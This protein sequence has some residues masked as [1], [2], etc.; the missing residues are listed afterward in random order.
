[1]NDWPVKILDKVGRFL[2]RTLF[3]LDVTGLENLPSTGPV[4][5][6][7]NHVNFTDVGMLMILMPRRPVGLA[8][9]ELVRNP[10]LGPIVRTLGVIPVRRGEV[11][12]DALRQSSELL[13]AGRRVLMI[14]P[15]GHRSGHGRL[16]E[17]HDG[18]TFVAIRSGAMLVPIATHGNERFWR[19]VFTLRKTRAHIVIGR[20]FRFRVSGGRPDR[21][22]LHAMTIEA[23]YRLA[24]LLPAEYRGVYSDLS[25]ATTKHLDFDPEK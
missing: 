22:A 7:T 2:I 20:G 16:Q 15:E 5:L 10:L 3:D 17:A 12:R 4:I 18:V 11:D 25:Q 8:K 24:A 23:M 9:E 14:A 1:V 21:L 6:L 19:N 13:A